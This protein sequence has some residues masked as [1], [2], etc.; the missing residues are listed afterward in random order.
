VHARVKNALLGSPIGPLLS[1][2]RANGLKVPWRLAWLERTQ[3]APPARLRALQNE[4]LR[5]LIRHA[6][7]HS[8]FYR[9]RLD[10][11]GLT[12]ERLQTVDDL[13]SLPPLT[14]NDV[15]D[16]FSEIKADNADHFRPQPAATSGTS[17]ARLEFLHD[18]DTISIGSAVQWRFM[19]W[20]GARFHHRFAQ[21]ASLGRAGGDADTPARYALGSRSLHLRLRSLDPRSLHVAIEHLAQFQPEV[22]RC[23]SP[24]LLTYVARYVLR[25]QT[26][27]LRPKVVVAMGER[28]FP[29]QRQI[30]QEAFGVPLVEMYGNWE[31]VMFAGECERGRLHLAPEMGYVE[32]L[33]DGRRQPPG[34]TGEIVVTGL[35]NRAFPFIRYAIGD[36]GRLDGEPCPCGRGLPTCQIIGGRQKDLLATPHGYLH[37]SGSFVGTPRWRSKIEG[38]RFYQETRRD[39]LVQVVKGPEFTDDDVPALREAINDSLEGRLAFG[40]QFCENLEETA[41]GKYRLTVSK[42]PIEI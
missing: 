16:Y 21:I 25:E 20:R 2:M 39:V 3:W 24:T 19:R 5:R 36:V 7:K 4:Q 38:I 11:A 28:I 34:A 31:Y 1:I 12:P 18:L 14:R 23:G 41:G 9:R 42:V 13:E 33:K 8:V 15:R 40:I 30:V 10:A 22:I 35:W 32:I 29:D 6:Y 37:L 27:R 26:H 17:G